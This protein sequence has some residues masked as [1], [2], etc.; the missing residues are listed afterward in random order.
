M[1]TRAARSEP[2]EGRGIEAGDTV[3]LDLDRRALADGA[4]DRH[5]D[6][7]IEIG[8]P[9]N[10]PG[11]D[12]ELLGLTAGAEK[13]FAITFPADYAVAE[14]A[15][16]RISFA[17]VK[18]I[19]KRVLPEL[20][21][22]FAKDVG[23]FDTLEALRERIRQDLLQNAQ[24]AADRQVRSDLLR[25]L[26]ARVSVEV[27]DALVERE[28]DRRVEEFA[29]RLI[30]QQVDP[31][32]ANIDWDAFRDGQREASRDAVK[33]ALVLDEI[34]RREHLAVTEEDIER[35]VA[36]YAERAGRT[37]AAIR[38]G[39]EKEGA[40]SRLAAGLRREKAVEFLLSRAQVIQE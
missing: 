35:D 18:A 9:A 38:A 39:L 20:D 30:D 17:K 34:S 37:P 40:L 16:T 3:A 14:M 33:S 10:P 13:T 19:H 1:R 7:S 6:V 24:A 15:G 8:A 22:E 5:D 29:R 28:L 31:R 21:D 12:D 26:A 25:A 23:E 32:N 11:F 36:A 27:P 4:G 2:V